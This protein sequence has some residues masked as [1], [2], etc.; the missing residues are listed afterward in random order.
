MKKLLVPLLLCIPVTLV[1]AQTIWDGSQGNG[2]WTD[3]LNWVGDV[4]PN[5]DSDKATFNNTGSG[6]TIDLGG[7]FIVLGGA[8]N[9]TILTL[10]E[11]SN[12]Y[13][14][15]NGTLSFYKSTGGSQLF[16]D[17]TGD[18]IINA[19]LA[20]GNASNNAPNSTGYIFTGTSASTL[21]INSQYL[22]GR[23][24]GQFRIAG[25]DNTI[26]GSGLIVDL[27]S[28]NDF[29]PGLGGGKQNATWYIQGGSTLR[30]N[31]DHTGSFELFNSGTLE[32]VGTR[33]ISG[34]IRNRG[35]NSTTVRPRITGGDLTVNGTY[36]AAEFF[37]NQGLEVTANSVTF[38]HFRMGGGNT[39]TNNHSISG[40]SGGAITVTGEFS[41]NPK[42]PGTHA[43]NLTINRPGNVF[44]FS[45][46]ST[47]A[48]LDTKAV[49]LTMES[50][51]LLVNSTAG[52]NELN[53]L[54]IENGA[55]LG[56]SGLITPGGPSGN[57]SITLQSG[58]TLAAGNSI[59]T[60]TLDGGQTTSTV[61]SLDA[62][63]VL[64]FELAGN[65]SAADSVA[66]W[67]FT[68]GDLTL[69]NNVINLTLD[70]A[71]VAGTYELDI[72][73][74]FSDAGSSGTLHGLSSG[75]S[76]GSLDANITSASIDWSG[77]DGTGTA[78]AIEYTVIPEP[79]A[80]LLLMTSLVPLM[81]SRRF[82]RC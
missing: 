22:T 16:I 45:A 62:G 58:S 12:P 28:T 51:T 9:E 55:T 13:T 79:S 42:N 53:S 23:N 2:L 38:T 66:F 17:V 70:G 80:A 52:I 63:S 56:G 61:L 59:G 18:H 57:G 78:I 7:S 75:L 8:D 47:S 20:M 33:E 5:G 29:D 64:E 30:L 35:G 26:A 43:R 60:L 67:N 50:G 40:N 37:T 32:V 49:N 65:G 27:H 19:N 54:V 21:T 39:S 48:D 24:F 15:N 34:G 74:F 71:L 69:N 72:F 44:E 10:D 25:G 68:S 46:S 41:A 11:A 77:S 73:G 14:L 1:Q 3:G 76:I 82:R 6:R 31:Q 81:L 36:T 4:A